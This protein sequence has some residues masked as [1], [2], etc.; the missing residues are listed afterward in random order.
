M[1]SN[2][3][4]VYFCISAAGTRLAGEVDERE[5]RDIAEH[6]YIR[7]KSGSVLPKYFSDLSKLITH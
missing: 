4:Q 5:M 2:I 6:F 3:T 1:Y 7:E